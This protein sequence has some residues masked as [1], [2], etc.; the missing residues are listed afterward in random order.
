MSVR[1]QCLGGGKMGEA[2]VRGLLSSGWARADEILV[3]E[4]LPARREELS[5]R[6]PSLNVGENL[7]PGIDVLLAIKPQ[8][9][10]AA[11][12]PGDLQGGA[13]ILSDGGRG[14]GFSRGGGSQ[15]DAGVLSGGTDLDFKE[16]QSDLDSKRDQPSVAVS[17]RFPRLLS[18]AAGVRIEVLQSLLG[19]ECR[20]LRAMPNTPALLGAGMAAVAAGTGATEDDLAW[21]KGILSAVGKV[22]VVEED[23]LDAVTG[24][25]GS[26][27][28]Y[29]FLVAEAMIA[30]GVE[31]GLEPE[32]ADILTR[33]TLLGSALLL[34]EGEDAPEQLRVNV[35]SPG[36]TTAEA[37]KVFEERDLRDIFREAILA[38]TERSKELGE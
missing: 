32:V 5:E 35:T 23:L 3:V 6:Y 15:E 8:D 22:V 28:A 16:G 31:A 12:S 30:A 19:S 14:G 11:L 21:A 7:E 17:A 29:L 25:S 10:A 36:G 37:L 13:E 34:A 27:P 18:I 4:A 24:V 33:Q 9:V 20:V 2:I 1:L 38:A 26:G